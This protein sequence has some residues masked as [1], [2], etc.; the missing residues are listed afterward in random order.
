MVMVMVMAMDMVTSEASEAS[1]AAAATTDP[2]MVNMDTE[3]MYSYG[4]NI[5]ERD[6]KRERGTHMEI[7]IL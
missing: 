3:G 7:C 6:R 5:M 1:V 2:A 4:L